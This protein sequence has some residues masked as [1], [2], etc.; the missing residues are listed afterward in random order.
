[1]MG[2]IAIFTVGYLLGARSGRQRYE[3]VVGLA[4]WLGRRE[5]LQTALGLAQGAIQTAL[6]R[7]Q[8]SPDVPRKR[9]AA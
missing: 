2:K 1:M 4:R 9:R 6:E 7:T 3:Q 8:Q 5:E